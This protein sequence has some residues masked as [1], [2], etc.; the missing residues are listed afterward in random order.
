MECFESELLST[1]A[2]GLEITWFRY[3]DEIFALLPNDL[4]VEYFLDSVNNLNVSIKF[5][6][7]IEINGTL[8][9]LDVMV[10]KNSPNGFP[11]FK[12]YRKPTHSNT[13][14]HAFSNH[15]DN[16]KIA[17]ISNIFLRA[18]NY[19][20]YNFIDDEISYI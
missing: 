15:S 2:N 7:E 5:T 13:Y 8:P 9:F 20:S 17:T 19:C 14:I 4:N 10:F 16:V 12:V 1:V 11:S 3:V 18:F 6:H